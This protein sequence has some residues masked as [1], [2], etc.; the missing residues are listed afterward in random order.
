MSPIEPLDF[1]LR[2]IESGDRRG[3]FKFQAT[4]GKGR[5]VFDLQNFAGAGTDLETAEGS[6]SS[7]TTDSGARV[8]EAIARWLG[9]DAGKR[10]AALERAPPAALSFVILSRDGAD[11]GTKL[12]FEG[13]DVELYFELVAGGSWGRLGVKSEGSAVEIVSELARALRD[14]P[15]HDPGVRPLRPKAALSCEE[16][17]GLLREGCEMAALVRRGLPDLSPLLATLDEELARE[18]GRG[19][20]VG[21]LVHLLLTTDHPALPDV[22]GRGLRA[23]ASQREVVAA[24]HRGMCSPLQK[25]SLAQPARV[26]AHD[27]IALALG[28]ALGCFLSLP[29]PSKR[30]FSVREAAQLLHRFHTPSVPALFEQHARSGDP[31]VLGWAAAHAAS[32]GRAEVARAYAG[33]AAQALSEGAIADDVEALA[34]T[35]LREALEELAKLPSTEEQR[36]EEQRLREIQKP[37]GR[38]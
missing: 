17:T 9:V 12:R 31:I 29:D 24:L 13:T 7:Q 19:F 28:D 1:P 32:E 33:R 4:L 8:V 18:S 38:R 15:D 26:E 10:N 37:H 27:S 30:A 35:A 11:V 5:C 25:L 3:V 20:L 2:R 22:V 36:E 14:G 16:L 21:N 6:L 34:A 23:P